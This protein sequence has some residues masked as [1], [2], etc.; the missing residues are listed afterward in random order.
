[1]H[2]LQKDKGSLAVN[3]AG[4]SSAFGPP[5][6]EIRNVEVQ[7]TPAKQKSTEEADMDEE[8]PDDTKT[9]KAA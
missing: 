2:N 1:M 8:T 4:L 6:S 9:N 7:T 5:L 3:A